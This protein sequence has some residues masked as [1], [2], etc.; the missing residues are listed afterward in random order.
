MTA[1]HRDHA[2]GPRRAR[3]AVLTVSDT[4]TPA[5]DVS[6]NLART[7]VERAG[8]EILDAAILPDEPDIVRQRI[9]HWLDRPDCDVIVTTG[10]TGVAPRDRTYEA[11][12]GSLERRLD[13]FGELFRMLSWEQVGAAAMLSRAVG[14]VARGRA[15]FALPGSPQAVELGLERLVLP[16]LGHLL[17][18]LGRRRD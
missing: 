18:Q 7:L 2:G 14:G 9:E 11:I 1:S 12:A 13:G 5:D 10:G 15:V 17:D 3:V 4:R 6:G 16:T 8:H